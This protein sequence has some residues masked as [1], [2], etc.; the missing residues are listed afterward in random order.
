MD[1]VKEGKDGIGE[2]RQVMDVLKSEYYRFNSSLDKSYWLG[3]LR[4]G[5]VCVCVCVYIYISLFTIDHN[6]FF[7]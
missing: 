6:C 3:K 5:C 2:G 1:R 4:Q 7:N